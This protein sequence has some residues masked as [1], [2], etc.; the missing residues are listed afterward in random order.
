[1]TADYLALALIAF[2]GIFGGL[3]LLRVARRRQKSR[4]EN[5]MA[6]DKLLTEAEFFERGR[7]VARATDQGDPFLK[8]MKD[9]L[10]AP[11]QGYSSWLDYAVEGMDTRTAFLELCVTEGESAPSRESMQMA[12]RY[13]LQELRRKAG[14]LEK[15]S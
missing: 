7:Q 9:K 5:V 1:M 10:P 13:E 15:P 3:W 2:V 14:E 12:V 4:T 11:P 6:D 8:A